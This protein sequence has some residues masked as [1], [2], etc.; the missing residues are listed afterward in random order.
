MGGL[1]ALAISLLV[2]LYNNDVNHLQQIIDT[3]PKFE[4]TQTT[5]I[6]ETTG[7]IALDKDI[8]EKILALNSPKN[9]ID[10]IDYAESSWIIPWDI[11]SRQLSVSKQLKSKYSQTFQRYILAEL[12]QRLSTVIK[13]QQKNTSKIASGIIHRINS[14]EC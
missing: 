13:Q 12:D 9:L 2:F 11:F 6:S 4:L 7:K 10:E 1:T 8:N 5:S 3:Y 14:T